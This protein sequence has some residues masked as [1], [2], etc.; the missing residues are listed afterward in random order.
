MRVMK[1]ENPDILAERVIQEFES[2]YIARYHH[3]LHVILLLLR[4]VS[5]SEV[6]RIFNEP[7]RTVQRWA[8]DLVKYGL[9]GLIDEVRPGRPPRLTQEQMAR[10]KLDIEKG[11][12]VFGYVQGLWDGPLLSHHIQ[13]HY[14]VGL[15]VRQCERIFHDI[16]YTLQRPRPKTVGATEA[17]REAFKKKR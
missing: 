10:V 15:G 9:S 6:A 2:T 4:G 16:G 11:P 5:T 7:K 3:R 12:Q 8:S 17:A 13:V 1:F 14:E